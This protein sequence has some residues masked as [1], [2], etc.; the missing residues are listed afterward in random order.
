MGELELPS[1]YSALPQQG[2]TRDPLGR[3]S[4]YGAIHH[5]VYSGI[6]RFPPEI[7]SL[8]FCEFASDNEELSLLYRRPPWVLAHVCRRWRAI[9]LGTRMLWRHL[10][11]LFLDI[12]KLPRQYEMVE[13]MLKRS[14]MAPLSFLLTK[15][16]DFP[17]DDSGDAHI[18]ALASLLLSHSHRWETVQLDLA[19]FLAPVVA[20]ADNVPMQ[21]L[22]SLTLD[23]SGIQQ[24]ISPQVFQD[25]TRLHRVNIIG[26]VDAH[27]SLG[28]SLAAPITRYEANEVSDVSGLTAHLQSGIR[29]PELILRT[30]RQREGTLDLSTL[31]TTK[32]LA[33]K[34]I[35]LECLHL[36]NH[37]S[38]SLVLTKLITPNLREMTLRFF[39]DY[40]FP[41][42]F[43]TFMHRSLCD[44]N[45]L[46]FHYYAGH[47][48]LSGHDTLRYIVKIPLNFSL[49]SLRINDPQGGMIVL[50]CQRTD[51][52]WEVLPNL[53]ELT[54]DVTFRRKTSPHIQRLAHARCNPGPDTSTMH[55]SMAPYTTVQKFQVSATLLAQLSYLTLMTDF[56]CSSS[57]ASPW[58]QSVIRL[59]DKFIKEYQQHVLIPFLSL[60]M[61]KDPSVRLEFFGRVE[62]LVARMERLDCNP[63]NV[64]VLYCLG[65]DYVIERIL[66]E[67]QHWLNPRELRLLKLRICTV[68]DRW[69][70]V[71][72]RIP[73]DKLPHWQWTVHGN[74]EYTLASRGTP[75]K[76]LLQFPSTNIDFAAQIFLFASAND[77][78]WPA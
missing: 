7:M 54:V 36:R 53:I 19:S 45:S 78:Y 4:R 23:A 20:G 55:A 75:Q 29:S 35:T 21:G 56:R 38:L 47:G 74:L 28:F 37:A 22:K 14:K 17:V 68:V 12:R 11:P 76:R 13:T 63:D 9:A 2:N 58:T 57:L 42:A 39:N 60:T 49:T 44:I 77:Y 70:H 1:M 27:V 67:R 41:P 24:D 50:L 51:N 43:E 3:D 31:A 30:N 72:H 34:S 71:L 33:L 8:V 48:S 6:E 15:C 64:I 25:A 5:G 10:P 40:R 62:R 66:Y 32:L 73:E 16:H 61:P 26:H 65:I 52:E 59:L 18:D 46:V 69:T